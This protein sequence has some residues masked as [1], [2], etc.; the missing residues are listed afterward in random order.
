MKILLTGATGY[1]GSLLAA[2]LT[3]A[4]YEVGCVVREPRRLGRL[5][6]L[7]GR[8]T[9]IP[10]C[11]MEQ[12]IPRFAPDTVI[13]TACTYARGSNTEEEIYQ[14]NLAFPFHVM[15]AAREAGIRRWINTSTLLPP[16]LNSYA[17]SKSQL[18]QW[19][20]IYAKRGEFQFVDLILE[21]FYGLD[22]PEGHFL[23][24]VLQKLEANEPLELTAGTQRRD[25]IYVEDVLN[26]Y[27]A[28]LRAPLDGQT[29]E[30][31]VGTGEAPAIR[32]VVEYMKALMGSTSELR[33]GAI[34]MRAGE[35]DSHCDTEKMEQLGVVQPLPWKEGIRR[36]LEA[37]THTHTHT[38]GLLKS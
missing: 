29:M 23:S 22:A 20:E 5:E 12:A 4:G 38:G 27:E 15:Q 11:E 21:H 1:L 26:V 3:A 25:F 30:I 16:M 10:A 35:P 36:W 18:V 28:V 24:W 17:L 13:N 33:F 32:E 19:G 37:S 7:C 14:G 2:R 9:I 34:P 31:P 6:T 8:V